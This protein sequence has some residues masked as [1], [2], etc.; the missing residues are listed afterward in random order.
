M[1][2]LVFVH[3]CVISHVLV[4]IL[5]LMLW[6]HKRNSGTFLCM[7]IYLKNAT[8]H[9]YKFFYKKTKNG[10]NPNFLLIYLKNIPDKMVLFLFLYIIYIFLYEWVFPSSENVKFW[11]FWLRLVHYISQIKPYLIIILTHTD[12]THSNEFRDI[13]IFSVLFFWNIFLFYGPDRIF[14]ISGGYIN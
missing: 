7:T 13:F 10:G 6:R 8:C 14:Y 3:N 2:F 9:H 11:L 12:S 5:I 1:I 4:Y